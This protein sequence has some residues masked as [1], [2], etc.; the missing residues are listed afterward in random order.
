M[1]KPNIKRTPDNYTRC[2]MCGCP[3]TSYEYYTYNCKCMDCWR[4]IDN[5]QT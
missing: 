4:C 3:I 2:I 5:E 1:D